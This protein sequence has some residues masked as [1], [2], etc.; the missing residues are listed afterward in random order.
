MLLRLV[1]FIVFA[2]VVARAFWRLVD[3]LLAGLSGPP[4]ARSS[5]VPT[6]RVQ[7]ARDPV[8][9]TFVLPDHA[10]TLVDGRVRLF[11]CSDTCRD[12]YQARTA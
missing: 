5:Q 7:M 9:G 4:R 10:L 6:R 8:C 11:F 3:G 2:I 12:K 1:V